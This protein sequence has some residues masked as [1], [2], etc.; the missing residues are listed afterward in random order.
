MGSLSFINVKVNEVTDVVS[1]NNA[2]SALNGDATHLYLDRNKCIAQRSLGLLRD[3]EYLIEAH[4]E[5]TNH[6]SPSDNH[7]KFSDIINRRIKKGQCFHTPYFGCRDYSVHFEA[8]DETSNVKSPYDGTTLDL[9]PMLYDLDYTSDP[10]GPVPLFF[11][12]KMVNGMID[13]GNSEVIR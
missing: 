11:R 8:Y 3:V 10:D 13:V 9:G 4:F 7:G 1:K 12:A 2:L 6:R 5:L